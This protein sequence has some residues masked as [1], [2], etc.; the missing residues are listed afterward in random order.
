LAKISSAMIN[1][2]LFLQ[3]FVLGD[4]PTI[5]I[6]NPQLKLA[7]TQVSQAKSQLQAI[8]IASQMMR[9]RFKGLNFRTYFYWW[10]AWQ[11][12]P[13]KLWSRTGFMHCHHQNFLLRLLLVKSG[14][15]NNKDISFGYS[16]VWYVSPHQ[17]LIVK[18][19]NKTNLALDP[20]HISRGA[21]PG[22][23][24]AGFTYRQLKS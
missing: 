24:A 15:F 23:Y 7:I 2:K 21:R 9:H 16:A 19:Q 10:R 11:I 12:N 1:L 4:E 13:N 17:Y 20:W 6:I 3:Y 8:E 14:W 5:E 18:L 22:E